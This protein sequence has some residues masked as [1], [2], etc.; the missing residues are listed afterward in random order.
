MPEARSATD[1]KSRLRVA[2]AGTVAAPLRVKYTDGKM[3]GRRLLA[4]LCSCWAALAQPPPT[5]SDVVARASAARQAND[6]PHAVELYRNALQLNPRWQEGWWF[7]GTL[8]YD[9]DQYTGARDALSRFLEFQPN[10]APALGLL[11][12]CEF[13]TARYGDALHHIELSLKDKADDQSQMANVLRYHR[14]LLLT[15]S[16]DFDAAMGLF[17]PFV[18]H[19]PPQPPLLEALGTAALRRPLAPAEIPA[20]Q[21]DLFQAAGAVAY[22]TLAHDSTS[23]ESAFAD[24]LDRFPA[25]PGVH[26][27]RGL[28]LLGTAPDHAIAEFK[29]EL[30]LNPAN[31]ASRA[32]L[33][34]ALLNRFEP[35]AALSFAS[36]A[37]QDAPRMATAQYALGRALAETGDVRKGIEHLELAVKLDPGNLENHMALASAYSKAGRIQ[38]ARTERTRSVEFAARGFGVTQP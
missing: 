3:E 30:E 9:S 2:V 11:G 27:L 14:A 21:K 1:P 19:M 28:Y 32:M 34:W 29:R 31:A 17:A 6:V 38:E 7:L 24:L 16:G 25:V 36:R 8:L 12:L 23:A 15:R 18:Q 37:A 10:A 4:M 22:R 35:E 33:A 26:H 5:F 20:Q 13:E